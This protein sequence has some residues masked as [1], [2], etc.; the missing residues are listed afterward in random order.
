MNGLDCEYDD[1]Q[2]A[3]AMAEITQLSCEDFFECDATTEI[4]EIWG[5]CGFGLGLLTER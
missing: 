4:G 1:A 3:D 5:D 2:A